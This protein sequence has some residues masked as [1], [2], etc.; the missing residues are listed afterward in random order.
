MPARNNPKSHLIRRGVGRNDSLKSPLEH[1]N[2]TAHSTTTTYPSQTTLSKPLYAFWSSNWFII[3]MVTAIVLAY[4]SPSIG[5][6]G[7]PMKPERYVKQIGTIVI[8]WTSG[9]NIKPSQLIRAASNIKVHILISTVSMGIIPL[10]VH[11]IVSP[12]FVRTIHF[13]GVTVDHETHSPIADTSSTPLWILAICNGLLVLSCLPSPVG[14]SVILTKACNGNEATSIFNSTLGSI[15]GVVVTPTLVHYYLGHATDLN[16]MHSASKDS[17]S[18]S[19]LDTLML[20]GR[21]VLFP[22][23]AGLAS[24]LVLL[25]IAPQVLAWPFSKISSVV[26]LLIIHSTFCD[27]FYIPLAEESAFPQNQVPFFGVVVL[28]LVLAVFHL[29]CLFTVKSLG[30]VLHLSRADTIAAMFSASQKSLTL[31]IPMINLLFTNRPDISLVLMPLLI[32][33]PTQILLGSLCSSMLQSWVD[34]E[35]VFVA[36]SQMNNHKSS[37]AIAKNKNT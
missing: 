28:T 26:L 13:L 17:Q 12:M 25:R 36:E 24:R 9:L 1:T 14:S 11:F 8:F 22:L 18:I 37:R 32:Y 34:A 19:I 6:T 5:R 20:L 35:P 21:S 29:V 3:C 33:H 2:D 7:G 31:G 16:S 30:G 27:A 23:L 10:F 4:I 15:I